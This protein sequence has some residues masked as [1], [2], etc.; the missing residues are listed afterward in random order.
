MYKHSTLYPICLG[1]V[2][3]LQFQL[4]K[5]LTQYILLEE[6]LR[7]CVNQT[8]HKHFAYL[9]IVADAADAVSVNFSG[10]CKFLQI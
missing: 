6:Y 10:R 1:G 8:L 9:I 5:V 2:L 3:R 7:I 4:D